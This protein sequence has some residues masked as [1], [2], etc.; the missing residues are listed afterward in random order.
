MIEEEDTRDTCPVCK[1]DTYLNPSLKL[2]VS[3][4][5]HRVCDSCVERLFSHGTAPCPVCSTTLRRGNFVLPTYEDAF[6]EK[7]CRIRK[8]IAAVF[9]KREDD[10]QTLKDYNDYLEE[11]EM[12]IFNLV[13]D[14]DVQKTNSMLEAYREQNLEQIVRRK[15][16]QEQ[17]DAEIKRLQEEEEQRRSDYDSQL[18][19]EIEADDEIRRTKENQF[20]EELAKS[21]LVPIGM[22]RSVNKETKRKAQEAALQ[23]MPSLRGL[24]ISKISAVEAS[25]DPF[26]TVPELALPIRIQSG[27]EWQDWWFGS[28]VPDAKVLAAG[29]MLKDL[30][31]N[32]LSYALCSYL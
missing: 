3:P 7:E 1:S 19:A 21:S 18:L 23:E 31:V 22:R 15:L 24:K 12:I 11:V 20:I 5:Y 10:F 6:V 17:E 13:N 14:V 16:V 8:R 2:L 30:V 26:E 25:F 9:N 32:N 28:K 27:G 29:G 4:C